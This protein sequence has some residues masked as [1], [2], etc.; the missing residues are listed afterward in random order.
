MSI[1]FQSAPLQDASE[2]PLIEPGRANFTAGF[3]GGDKYFGV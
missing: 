3:D 1:T 2:A